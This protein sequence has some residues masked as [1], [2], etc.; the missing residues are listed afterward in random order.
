VTLVKEVEPIRLEKVLEKVPEKE[1]SKPVA[2]PKKKV[3]FPKCK[4]CKII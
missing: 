1:T 4:V 2:V 3:S